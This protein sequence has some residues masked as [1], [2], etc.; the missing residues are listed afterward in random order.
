MNKLDAT[1]SMIDFFNAKAK[2]SVRKT[3]KSLSVVSTCIKDDFSN[4]DHLAQHIETFIVKDKD[5]YKCFFVYLFKY[6]Y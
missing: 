3:S 2:T 5:F 6:I 4:L 1:K